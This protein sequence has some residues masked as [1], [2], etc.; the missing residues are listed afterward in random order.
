M[1]KKLTI[2]ISTIFL[3]VSSASAQERM[4]DPSLFKQPKLVVG[5]VV[6]QMRADYIYRYW[7]KLSEKG[8][9]RLVRQGFECSNTQYNYVPT[10]TGPGH[11]SIYTGTTPE[12][13]GIIGNNWYIKVNHKTTYCA[14]DATEHAV[15]G[16]DTSGWMSPRKLLTTTISDELRLFSNF[17]SKSIGIS[18]K[19]RA[20]I[21][22]AGHSGRAYW[23]DNFTNNFITSTYY[24]KPPEALPSWVTKFNLRGLPDQYLKGMWQPLLPIDQYTESTIDNT[25]YENTLDTS[26]AS[27]PVFN[28][29]LKKLR[30]IDKDLLRRTPFGNSLTKE[31]A[32]AAI[33]GEQLGADDFC[34]MLAISFSSTDYVGHAFGTN[35]IETEDTYLRLDH[36]LADLFDYLEKNIGMENVLIFLTADHAA[37]PNPVFMKDNSLPG[38]YIYTDTITSAIKNFFIQNYNDTSIFSFYINDQVYLNDSLIDAKRYSRK[39]IIEKL[40]AELMK[41]NFISDVVPGW[42]L[43]EEEYISGMR[44]MMKRGYNKK[45]S[46]DIA[47]VY[48]S[49]YIE[50]YGGK[51]PEAGTT[52]GS[53]YRYDTMVPLYWY[54]WNIKK[55][56]TAREIYITDVAA[57]LSALLSICQPSGCI[58]KPI[59]E[60][61]AK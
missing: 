15:G 54:G 18:L 8:F 44:G 25:L 58:G 17:R 60:L 55:G 50:S 41:F 9:K 51:R 24:I 32:I 46:G 22:P 34:D 47:L 26:V 59:V 38:G 61:L 21:F 57:T 11:A 35:A 36:D 6:D 1:K 27:L 49:G 31:M 37:S 29:D 7:N 4:A 56:K 28:Y 16:N 52:H 12:V 13:H 53:P 42:R 43:S 48:H 33:E 45:R 19:D 5:I 3:V 20:S 14:A 40:G 23:Y 2:F 10:Y 39:E 30:L